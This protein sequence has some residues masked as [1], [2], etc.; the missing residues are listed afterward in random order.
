MLS[1]KEG[2]TIVGITELRKSIPELLGKIKNEKVIVTKRNR[3]I[4]ILVDFE[5]YEKME[6]SIEYIE[7]YLLGHLAKA[8]ASRKDRK[9]VTL[10]E[11]EKRVGLG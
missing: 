3:P 6:E 4:G 2:A 8:R 11:A 5:E 10:A 1:I 7:D 9:T